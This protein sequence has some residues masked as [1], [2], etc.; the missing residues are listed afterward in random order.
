MNIWDIITGYFRNEKYS[1][2]FP[3]FYV[4]VRALLELA[5]KEGLK[6]GVFQGYRSYEEQARLYAKGRT[7][8]G[9]RVTKARPGH[10]KHNFGFAA[11]FVFKK[12]G[13]WSWA[14]EHPWDR[15]G[16]LGRSVG[17]EWGGDWQS[18]VDRPHF[19]WD[20]KLS[21]A[22]YRE[23]YHEQGLGGIWLRELK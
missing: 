19:Q 17:L 18:F 3:P 20:C 9:R 21:L 4:K 12:Q 13:R 16:A 22:D 14:E 6:V 2:L 23:L 11:D 8:P 15:L 5:E 7:K 10:S 1:K